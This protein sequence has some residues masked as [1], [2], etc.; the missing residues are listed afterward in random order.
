MVSPFGKVILRTHKPAGWFLGLCAPVR[1]ESQLWAI[2]TVESRLTLP[3]P[4]A[5]H[6]DF[7]KIPRSE[8][9]NFQYLFKAK[10]KEISYPDSS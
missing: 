4:G 9:R 7:A 1:N 2:E 3:S 6:D 10:G 8:N 5:P